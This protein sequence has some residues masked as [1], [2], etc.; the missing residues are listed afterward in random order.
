MQHR[1]VP[2]LGDFSKFA[3]IDALSASGADRTALI[4]YLVNPHEVNEAHNNDG[5]HTAYLRDDRQ[6]FSE[7]HPRLYQRFRDIDATGEKHVGV[8]ARRAILPNVA[9]FPEPLSYDGRAATEREAYRAGWLERAMQIATRSD[10]VVLD[11]DN[12]LMPERITPR[13]KSAIK[14]ASLDECAAFYGRGLR[15]LVVYQHAHRTGSAQAQAESGLDRLTERLGA[16]RSI[17]F[18]LRF[19]RGT[20]RFYFVLSAGDTVDAMRS[21]AGAMIANGWGSRGHFSL[22]E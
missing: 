9:Y 3:V 21:R 20:T 18:A 7:C 19:H 6:G 16:D 13:S 17:A 11:P 12:G 1:Y 22:V 8:Y 2:D 4:W 15:T 10:V 14:Y 5:K